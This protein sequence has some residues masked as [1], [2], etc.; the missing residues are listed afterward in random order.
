MLRETVSCLF[1]FAVDH[2]V[3]FKPNAALNCNGTKQRVT[4]KYKGD[5][6]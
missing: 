5:E 3:R 6:L 1:G 2:C 4:M